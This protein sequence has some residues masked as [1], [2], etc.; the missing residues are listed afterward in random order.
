MRFNVAQMSDPRAFDVLARA[1]GSHADG[2]L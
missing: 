2:E 1:L